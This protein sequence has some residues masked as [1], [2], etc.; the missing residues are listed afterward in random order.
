MSEHMLLAGIIIQSGRSHARGQRL[1][2]GSAVEQVHGRGLL[3]FDHVDACRRLEGELAAVQ[4]L[5]H[6]H[7]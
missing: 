7:P 1:S 6:L 3:L 2:N 4:R 5:I